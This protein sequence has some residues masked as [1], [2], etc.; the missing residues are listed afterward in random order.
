MLSV[1]I[2]QHVIVKKSIKDR[3]TIT[4]SLWR[5]RICPIFVSQQECLTI[6]ADSLKMKRRATV[7]F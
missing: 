2:V 1:V 3:F 6:L 7:N 5:L 4:F